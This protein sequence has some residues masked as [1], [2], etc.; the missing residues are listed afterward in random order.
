MATYGATFRQLRIGKN[1]T[2]KELADEQ[3][4]VGFLSKFETDQSKISVD[5]LMHLLDKMNVTADEYFFAQHDGYAMPEVPKVWS[6]MSVPNVVAVLG[7]SFYYT[8]GLSNRGQW[9]KLARWQRHLAEQASSAPTMGHWLNF[10]FAQLLLA[11]H[12]QAEPYPFVQRAITYLQQIDEWSIY[13]LIVFNVFL[14][15]MSVPDA[16]QLALSA[17]HK[18]V[19]QAPLSEVAG[20]HR[21]FLVTSFCFFMNRTRFDI[22]EELLGQMHSLH[23]E[24]SPQQSTGDFGM[25]ILWCQGWLTYRRDSEERGQSQMKD[26]LTIMRL[27]EEESLWRLYAAFSER[28]WQTKD[29][30]LLYHSRLM[31]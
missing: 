3:V 30:H 20:M 4:S 14:Q 5:R 21:G 9:E 6:E 19:S 17:K 22:A 13:E 1:M 2:L 29:D 10:D 25:L 12:Q 31:A 18:L 15:G 11:Q 26:A 8:A 23:K 24:Q 27:C 28:I 7:S 16:Q